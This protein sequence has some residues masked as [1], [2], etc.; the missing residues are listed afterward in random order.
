V[1]F[2]S[3]KALLKRIQLRNASFKYLKAELRLH[4]SQLSLMAQFWSPRTTRDLCAAE[5]KFVEQYSSNIYKMRLLRRAHNY[6]I[7]IRARFDTIWNY[8]SVRQK[9]WHVAFLTTSGIYC[10]IYERGMEGASE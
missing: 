1:L 2:E 10:I 6:H 8:S 7:A 9:N 4:K 5:I 3:I